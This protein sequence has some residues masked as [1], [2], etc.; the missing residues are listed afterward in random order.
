[1]SLTRHQRMGLA[2]AA[3]SVTTFLAGGW[4]LWSWTVRG[5]TG[6]LGV[7]CAEA[8]HFLRAARLPDGTH[9]RRCTMGN[10]M[11]RDYRLDLRAPRESTERWLRDAYPNMELRRYCADSQLCAEPRVD[12]VLF[13]DR[14]GHVLAGL[15]SVEVDFEGSDTAHLRIF[16]MTM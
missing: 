10:F 5:I 2:L 1:M 14:H 8:A 16:G 15:I 11:G 4:Y 9:D 12:P 7:P 3:A 6:T 13:K